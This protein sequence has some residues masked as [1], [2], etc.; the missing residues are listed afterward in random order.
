MSSDIRNATPTPIVEL[1][2]EG[3]AEHG[4]ASRTIVHLDDPD[5]ARVRKL[6]AEPFRVREI[7]RLGRAGRRQGVAAALDRRPRRLGDQTV[8]LDLVGDLAYPLP[9]EIFS[10]WLGMPEEA[11]PQFRYWTSWVA[12]SRDPMPPDERAEFYAALDSMHD[13]LADQAE[14]RSAR[15]DRR[16]PVLPRARRGRRR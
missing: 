5:H 3:L 15:A 7:N 10:E 16:P 8:T 14:T 6:M 13:Y 4:R 2:L 1:E 12:R 11:T 9:V